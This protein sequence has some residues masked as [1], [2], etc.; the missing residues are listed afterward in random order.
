MHSSVST[1]ITYSSGIY[2]TLI[3]NICSAHQKWMH[4]THWIYAAHLEH[5]SAKR[6]KMYTNEF[7][8]YIDIYICL[9]FKLRWQMWTLFV[10][11]GIRVPFSTN[12][13]ACVVKSHG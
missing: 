12:A 11:S 7:G 6:V 8:I 1:S 10:T 5:I 9:H 3:W 13:P 4:H 2:G